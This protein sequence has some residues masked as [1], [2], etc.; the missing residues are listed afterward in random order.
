MVFY[1]IAE[2]EKVLRSALQTKLKSVGFGK[3]QKSVYISPLPLS[4]ELEE[5]IAL[6]N[7][8]ERVF[9]GVCRRL[10]A[11][12]DKQLA[13][14]V[15]RLDEL[16]E[17][18]GEILIKIEESVQGGNK[19]TIDQLYHEFEQVLLDDPLL[20]QEL[21]PEWWVGNEALRKMKEL[22]RGKR[23]KIREI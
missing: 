10:L 14:R 17:R 18:Y 11:G 2:K 23:D 22:L 1:D 13:A 8:Q 12:D 7:L 5:F 16:N 3:L 4:E 20:P 21:L 15:W 19:V 9:V 6:R